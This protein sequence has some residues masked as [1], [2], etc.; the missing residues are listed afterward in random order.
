M[1]GHRRREGEAR[2]RASASSSRATTARELIRQTRGQICPRG[3]YLERRGRPAS[4]PCCWAIPA[5]ASGRQ[6]GRSDPALLK[7][8][9]PAPLLQLPPEQPGDDGAELAR[10]A[11]AE[12]IGSRRHPLYEFASISV[13]SR[14]HGKVGARTFPAFTCE[15]TSPV[16]TRRSPGGSRMRR[17][18]FGG[19]SARRFTPATLADC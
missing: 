18:R 11:T 12:A 13:G 9:R 1:R 4:P 7:S 19:M 5:R 16:Q 8:A 17:R 6:R 10:R 3:A 14:T 15:R 2:W